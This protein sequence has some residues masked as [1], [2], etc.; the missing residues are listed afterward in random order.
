MLGSVARRRLLGAATISVMA[1]AAPSAVLGHTINEKYEAPLPLVAYVAGAALAVGMSFVFVSLRQRS[2]PPN[3][4]L[5]RVRNVSPLIRWPLRA[6]GLIAWIWIMAQAFFGGND[7]SAD[8]G[9]L[10]LWIYGWI[11]LALISALGGPIWSWLDPFSTMHLLLV[12]AGR[13]LHLLSTPEPGEDEEASAREYP[14]RLGRWP[15]VIAFAIVIWLEL[16]AFVTGGKTLAVVLLG[17][18]LFTLAGMSWFG[19]PVWR[20]NVEVFSVWFWLL[21][22]LAPYKQIG[23][24]EQNQVARRPFASGLFAEPWTRTDLVLVT[25]GT[26]AIIFDGLSQTR[27]Y[28]DLIGHIDVLPAVAINTIA[29]LGWFALIL[30]IVFSVARR[31]GVNALGAGLLPVAIGY[32]I[33]HYI[34]TLLFDG[35]R[36]VIAVNDPLVGGISLLPYPLSNMSQPWAFLPPS[37]IWTIQLAAVVGGHVV[38]AWAGHAALGETRQ[39]ARLANQLPLAVLMVAFTSITLWSLG[40]EVIVPPTTSVRSVGPPIVVSQP[41][42]DVAPT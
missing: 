20:R 30:A 13:R 24:P 9:Q 34:I 41:N 22:R 5:G 37:I 8:V 4:A 6:L 42:S 18:T 21:G 29:L 2:N 28:F 36:I 15:A 1:F 32:L 3:V 25:L 33:A 16:V 27:L 26:A 35:Q 23:E 38:G 40:Q 17:Y 12:G 19:R 7:P 39:G 14:V 31:I 10:F 11:G